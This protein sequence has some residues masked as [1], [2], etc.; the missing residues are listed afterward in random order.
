MAKV[1][2]LGIRNWE[3]GE[4]YNTLKPVVRLKYCRPLRL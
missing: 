2:E 3:L 4:V 1:Q